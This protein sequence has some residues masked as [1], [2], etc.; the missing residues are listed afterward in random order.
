MDIQNTT[1][2]CLVIKCMNFCFCTFCIFQH[3]AP[4]WY[5]KNWNNLK[6]AEYFL[7]KFYYAFLPVAH[8]VFICLLYVTNRIKA[9]LFTCTLYLKKKNQYPE[10]THIM[11]IL[12]FFILQ[13]SGDI[14]TTACWDDLFSD[15]LRL[16]L[17]SVFTLSP[18]PYR[19]QHLPVAFLSTYTHTSLRQHHTVLKNPQ[20][21][22]NT[23]IKVQPLLFIN[24]ANRKQ[25][26]SLVSLKVTVS[27][28][29][30]F[31]NRRKRILFS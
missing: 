26:P 15:K 13:C 8:I 4:G 25:F 11:Q 5:L 23:G 10:C 29:L 30:K 31:F 2:D 28:F 18:A 6:R 3:K 7:I 17:H 1:K 9:F 14:V 24:T 20:K 16:M 27:C 21:N 12:S 19:W 22:I